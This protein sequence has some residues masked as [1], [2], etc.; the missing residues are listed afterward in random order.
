MKKVVIGISIA[1]GVIVAAIAAVLYID[2]NYKF[3][4]TDYNF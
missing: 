4:F 2:E 1:I 3:D